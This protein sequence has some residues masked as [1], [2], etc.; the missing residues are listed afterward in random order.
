MKYLVFS[1]LIIIAGQ[2]FL[3]TQ[4]RAQDTNFVRIN[5]W[6][7]ENF[8]DSTCTWDLF[9]EAFI[10]I[11]PTY[12]EAFVFDQVIYDN[13]FSAM[14]NS[15]HCFGM[16]LAAL[17]LL[18]YG[19]FDGI[20]APA[21]Q[22]PRRYTGTEYREPASDELYHAIQMLQPHIL[23][24]RVVSHLLDLIAQNKSRDGNYAFDQY[25]YYAAKKGYSIVCITE[26][27]TNVSDSHALL[28][29]HTTVDGAGNKRIYVYDV[30]RPFNKPGPDGH[31]WYTSG[32]NY[33]Q[34][35]SSDGKWSF[36]MADTCICPWS[37]VSSSFN[38]N[39]G[40]IMIVPF[41]IMRNK[42]RL[43]QSLFADGLEAA[44]KLFLFGHSVSLEQISTP[45]GKRYFKPGAQLLEED[46]SLA[47]RGIMPFFP[48]NG[49]K[50][51]MENSQLYFMQDQNDFDITVRGGSDG[52]KI[53]LFSGQA[54]LT[55]TAEKPNDVERICIRNWQTDC[56]FVTVIKEDGQISHS[57]IDV[58]QLHPAQP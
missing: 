40:H 27:Y 32:N 23:N 54:F 58:Q 6:H 24:F 20:C 56:P 42:D 37:G 48:M 11:P 33:I 57:F 38:G 8:T 39:S 15:G 36:D 14:L 5:T 45:D 31:D 3:S 47:L 25:N 2:F 52:Y 44:S 46:D 17:Q 28:P 26:S 30:N 7:F 9:R 35:N 51:P 41:S 29:Y 55:V 50:A 10:G 53:Q 21:S 13:V 49:C 19:G 4:A 22:Y 34:I 43:P 12:S 18:R 1:L 16:S